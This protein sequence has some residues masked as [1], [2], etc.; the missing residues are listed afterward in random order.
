MR[1]NI[2]YLKDKAFL[3]EITRKLVMLVILPLGLILP[4]FVHAQLSNSY[5]QNQ[6]STYQNANFW[7][8]GYGRI[9]GAEGAYKNYLKSVF[10]SGNAFSGLVLESNGSINYGITGSFAPGFRFRWLAHNNGTINY[11]SGDDMIMYLEHDGTLT[12]KNKI[13]VGVYPNYYPVWTSR[14][15]GSG[16]GLDADM[17]D[18]FHANGHN[19]SSA[20][21]YIGSSGVIEMGRYMDFHYTY[22]DTHVSDYDVRFKILSNKTLAIVGGGN[23]LIGKE[24]QTNTS[25]RLDVNGNIRANKVVV[26]TSGADY[27]FD[28]AYHLM[29]LD[30]LNTYIKQYHH[31]PGIPSAEK[32]QQEGL[33]IGDAYTKLLGKMEE[34]TKYLIEMKKTIKDQQEEIEQ[35]KRSKN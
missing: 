1:D 27:V 11:A 7:I 22:T 9:G 29:P 10:Y 5:I 19:L 26:N 12:V 2:N 16:S 15:D 34:M 4:H 6:T 14:N 24:S 21:P 23:V 28:S 20:I 30:S 8:N 18:G 3:L 17:L 25:Y 33:S 31:L 32:M 13:R 35:L